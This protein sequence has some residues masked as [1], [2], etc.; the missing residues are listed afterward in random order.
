MQELCIMLEL[1]VFKE[2]LVSNL[3]DLCWTN[4]YF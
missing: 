2:E 4:L 3:V 1:T